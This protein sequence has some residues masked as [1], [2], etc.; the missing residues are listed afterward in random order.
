MPEPSHKEAEAYSRNWHAIHAKLKLAFESSGHVHLLFVDHIN[1]KEAGWHASFTGE[2]IDVGE[3]PAGQWVDVRLLSHTRVNKESTHASYAAELLATKD[4][5]KDRATW[6]PEQIRTLYE[7]WEMSD[8]VQGILG[9]IE[10][11]SFPEGVTRFYM[12]QIGELV[13]TTLYDEV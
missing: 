8:A 2:A 13:Q 7:A 1:P 10:E 3:D 6:T 12:H 9:N 4:H 5:P 11:L